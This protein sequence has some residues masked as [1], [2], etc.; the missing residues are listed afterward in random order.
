MHA[1][2]NAAAKLIFYDLCG[3]GVQIQVMASAKRYED[4]ISF[5][6]ETAIIKRGDIIAI[7]GSPGR[8][9][10][11]ELSVVPRRMQ[12]LS[13]CL[14]MLPPRHFGVKNK[15]RVAELRSSRAGKMDSHFVFAIFCKCVCYCVQFVL[16]QCNCVY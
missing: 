11:G 6:N 1:I 13:P 14:H 9:K 16:L 7:E 10:Y 15:V 12:L 8:T 4:E 5:R 3:E 2:R